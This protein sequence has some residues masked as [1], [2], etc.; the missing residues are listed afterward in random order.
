MSK[1][2][3]A[4]LERLLRSAWEH[5]IALLTRQSMGGKKN[6]PIN[7]PQKIAIPILDLLLAIIP[8][9][10]EMPVM[11]K[12]LIWLL[13][14]ILLILYVVP[15]WFPT[16]S[17]NLSK[18]RMVSV[19]VIMIIGF[20]LGFFHL[21]RAQWIGEQSNVL[22]GFL[23]PLKR[24]QNPQADIEWGFGSK[25]TIFHYHYPSNDNDLNVLHELGFTVEIK[26]G[27]PVLTT[28]VKDRSGNI[29]AII[30]QNHWTVRPQFSLDKNYTQD[31]LEVLDSTGHSVI[32]VRVLGDLIQINGEWRDE[33]GQG[34]EITGDDN[35]VVRVN[36]W[37]NAHE[38]METEKAL[39]PIFN[40][41]SKL[42]WQQFLKP[43]PYSP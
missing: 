39:H 6:I 41:P 20:I 36:R 17:D 3:R 19:Q 37:K 12:W 9:V 8:S 23:E 5:Q 27:I 11:V 22:E 2:D 42:Y 30:A 31:T 33:Y 24:S 38:E 18:P 14:W 21:A 16:L 43:L 1:G 35:G 10:V 40:Y 4:N 32:Q 34:I 25:G 7:K 13:A 28:P 26:N 15:G 29:I